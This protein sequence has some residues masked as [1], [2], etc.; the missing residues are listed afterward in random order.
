MKYIFYLILFCTTIYSQCPDGQIEDDCEDCWQSY[1]YCLSD[2]TPN[3]NIS[4]N[5][6]EEQSCW[7][8][9]PGGTYEP[10]DYEFCVFD[11]YW[12]AQCTGCADPIADNYDIN[13]TIACD[14]NCDE[15]TGDCCEYELNNHEIINNSLKINQIF[16][17]PFNPKTNIT[18]NIP[19]YDFIELNIYNISGQ[20]IKT[21]YSNYLNQGT[22]SFIW[23]AKNY[24]SGIYIVKISARN[25]S[26]SYLIH[27][28]K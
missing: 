23:N 3:F 26:D 11:P 6:C 21:I 12:N 4:Q 8:I 10:G 5:Q 24:Q 18:I 14:N 20:L 9:G 16:P 7:W 13:A 2:H 15:E 28:L 27:L 19:S 1:C 25:K 22:H 17:N